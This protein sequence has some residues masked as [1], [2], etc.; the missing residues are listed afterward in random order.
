M[1]ESQEAIEKRYQDAVD[2]LVA[3]VK[4]DRN[5]IAAILGGSF[6]YDQV[7][8]KSDL[9]IEL[10]SRDGINRNGYSLVENGVN[11]H[12]S[13][14]PR[15][16]FKRTLEG[17]R[18]GS[19]MH[20]FFSRSTLLF[21]DDES[22]KEWYQQNANLHG[23]GA[24]DKELQL[25]SVIT[26]PLS[27]LA[28]AEKQF[29]V[30]NDL[31]YSFTSILAAVEELARVE[32]LLNDENPSRE[33]IQPALE[34]NP[35]FFKAVY[36]D[37]L[38]R[39][40]DEEVIQDALNR[41]NAYLDEK[42]FIFQPILD[43]LA[44][45]EGIRSATELNTYFGE[46]MGEGTRLDNAYQW[47]ARKGVIEQISIP[48]KLTL[49]SQI[50]VEEAAYYYHPQETS[51][52]NLSHPVR[53]KEEA[54]PHIME[55][56]DAF[57]YKIKSD[58]YILAVILTSDL[59]P[60][61]VWDKTNVEISLISRDD[62]RLDAQSRATE[63]ED[64]RPTPRYSLVEND[65]N[66]NVTIYRRNEYKRMVEGQLQANAL[67]S[68]LLRSK[69]L[70]SKDETIGE[71]HKNLEY[72]G[73]R[74]R[75]TRLMSVASGAFGALAK[76][77]KWFFVKHDY[78]YSFLYLTFVVD[79]LARI[80]VITHGEVPKRKVIY[81]ALKYNPDFFNAVYV[82]LIN[83]E[84]TKET[85]GHALEMIDEY[86]EDKAFTVFQPLF[87]FLTEAG[88]IRTMTEIGDHFGKRFQ[89]GEVSGACEWLAEKEILEQVSSPLR[90]TKDSRVSVEEQAYYYDESNP[91]WE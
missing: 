15:N 61:N 21:S 35:D 14:T 80:E 4:K 72:I 51:A 69:I 89:D 78:D 70:F 10:I 8:E 54:H 62:A 71:W 9:D 53:L 87:D 28:Y 65:V 58:R 64:T 48:T 88:G 39:E 26:G 67:H 22:I 86:L 42:L 32:V 79:S 25:L 44:E 3:K 29:Y 20:S 60:H 30:N 77:E 47:L 16:S 1:I 90:L 56:L 27:S 24:R 36:S 55:A 31:L 33:V 34:Y 7:W 52:K 81:Q 11:I 38:N 41:V 37:L 68:V 91:L 6:S 85:V 74:D 18:Q 45:A 57:V 46:K 63:E 40:K 82:D 13:V 75:E 12:A 19:F 83:A 23:I 73:E 50:E 66:I 76:A 84:K 43:Y 5:I 49:K 2:S 59:A 17:A